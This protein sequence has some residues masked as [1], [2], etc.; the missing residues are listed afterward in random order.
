[1]KKVD[2]DYPPQSAFLQCYLIKE[3]NNLL[4]DVHDFLKTYP[5]PKARPD[6]YTATPREPDGA[7]KTID[8]LNSAHTQ[9]YLHGRISEPLLIEL[10]KRIPTFAEY[11]NHYVQGLQ[12]E[13]ENGSISPEFVR[14]EL[15]RGHLIDWIKPELGPLIGR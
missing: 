7:A 1:M 4:R 3:V 9:L 10:A 2:T 11:P 8:Y 13:I 14:F 15:V 5:E 6:L 12:D